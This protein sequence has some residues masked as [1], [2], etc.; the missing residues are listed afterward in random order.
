M[1]SSRPELVVDWCSYQAAKYAVEKWH[2]SKRMPRSKMNTLGVWEASCFIG[3]IV[4]SYGATP[5]IGSPYGLKQQQVIEL[6]RVALTGHASPVTQALSRAVGLVKGHGPGLRLIVSFADSAEGHL[7]TIYQA[8]N[9]VYAGMTKTGR[10]GFVVNG[11]KV[12]TRTIGLKRGGVQSLEWVRANLD[13]DAKQWIGSAKHRYLYPLDRA[14]RRQI[15]PLARP[16]PKRETCG[17]SVQGDMPGCQ[18]GEAGS[19]PAVRS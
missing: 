3:A 12:H 10:V 9:W 11:Q 16:Y 6:T 2:Y 18:P 1:S 15:A 19:S 13:R 14:M 5:Q 8:A 4:F 7:G 17:P